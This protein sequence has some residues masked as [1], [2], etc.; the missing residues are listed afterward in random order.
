MTPVEIYL[1]ALKSGEDVPRDVLCALWDEEQQR[2][3]K[4]LGDKA[5]DAKLE[6]FLRWANRRAAL[7]EL[8]IDPPIDQDIL[9]L[10]ASGVAAYLVGKKPWPK[11]RGNKEKRDLMWECYWRVNFYSA[12]DDRLP[13]HKEGGGAYCVVGDV[14]N[15]SPEN[16]ESHVRNAKALLKTAEGKKDFELWLSDYRY[17]G[18]VVFISDQK[19]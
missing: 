16:V 18:G 9:N 7:K 17:N 1:A 13:Q 4:L 6:T 5:D 2:E 10:V 12:E 15:F 11:K 19:R 8:G 14:L 3:R